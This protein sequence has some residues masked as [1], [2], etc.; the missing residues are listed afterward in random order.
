MA[1]EYGVPRWELTTEEDTQEDAAGYHG[2]GDRKQTNQP[3]YFPVD[4][5]R[6][7]ALAAD[8]MS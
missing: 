6:L 5:V 8:D 3:A 2:R 1:T 7:S 4:G